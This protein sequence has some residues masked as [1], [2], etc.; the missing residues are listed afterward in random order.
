MTRLE[1]SDKL[2][3]KVTAVGNDG[4]AFAE[5]VVGVCEKESEPDTQD[6]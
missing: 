4:Y 1:L 5:A 3:V 2:G 6:A